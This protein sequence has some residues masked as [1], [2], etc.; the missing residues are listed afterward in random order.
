[1]DKRVLKTT[2]VH[3]CFKGAS[4]V[5]RSAEAIPVKVKR[6]I[7]ATAKQGR[8]ATILIADR[9]GKRELARAV[10]GRASRVAL[11]LTRKPL[12]RLQRVW[13]GAREWLDLIVLGFAGLLLWL[14]FILR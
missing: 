12:S 13:A 6:Q 14:A 1:V 2:V 4:G 11:R 9:N 8:S 10:R 5:F 3:V 7:A